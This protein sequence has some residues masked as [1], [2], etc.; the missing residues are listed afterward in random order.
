VL[1]RVNRIVEGADLRRTSRQGVKFRSP[2]VLASWVATEENSPAR[3]GFIVSKQVGGAVTRNTVKRRL[4][5]LAAQTL[6]EN[7]TGYDVVVRAQAAS[8]RASFD[9]LS[10]EWDRLVTQLVRT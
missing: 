3:F 5:A 8:A 9:E 6:G 4:R 7:L 2:L 1:A 10:Q